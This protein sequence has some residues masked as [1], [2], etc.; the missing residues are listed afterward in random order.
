[1]EETVEW[2]H[3]P[4]H[5]LDPG[6]LALMEGVQVREGL[7]RNPSFT[8]YLIPTIPDVPPMHIDVLEIGDPYAPYGLRSLGEPPT[9]SSTPR[10]SPRCATRPAGRPLTVSR[11]GPTTSSRKTG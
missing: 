1:M 4:T 9:I 6:K 10:S 2:R 8:D 7:V 5:P 11:S 3:R